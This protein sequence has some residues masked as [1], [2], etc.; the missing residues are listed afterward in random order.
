M[1]LAGLYTSSEGA[2]Q[3]KAM[4]ASVAAETEPSRQRKSLGL[5][6][7]DQWLVVSSKKLGCDLHLL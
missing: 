4:K 2:L 7:W 1:Y 5:V 3:W 6:G